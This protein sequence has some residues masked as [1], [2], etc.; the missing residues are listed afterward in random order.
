VR[1]QQVRA[2]EVWRARGDTFPRAV[3][4]MP[5]DFAPI[6]CHEGPALKKPQQNRFPIPG[7][8]TI[9]RRIE[10]VSVRMDQ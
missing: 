8:Q 2:R 1:A 9:H 7:A 5:I 6:F 4:L 3:S 10:H